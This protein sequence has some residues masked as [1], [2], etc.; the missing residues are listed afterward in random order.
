MSISMWQHV[1]LIYPQ[2]TLASCWDVKLPTNNNY[3]QSVEFPQGY[4]GNS[5]D[6]DLSVGCILS[7]FLYDALVCPWSESFS[8]LSTPLPCQSLWTAIFFMKQT[9]SM[10]VFPWKETAKEVRMTCHDLLWSAFLETPKH[11]FTLK[12][13][14]TQS[15][16]CL[17][18]HFD[19]VVLVNCCMSHLVDLTYHNLCHF[20][21]VCAFTCNT[22]STY[23]M[24]HVI[25]RATC[26]EGTAQACN[27]TRC[28]W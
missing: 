25:L 23:H 3:P 13:W 2:D 27:T 22:S 8:S 17:W 14:K 16:H 10:W 18:F 21:F 28:T 15:E 7:P 9:M 6:V 4:P 5:A 26:Y 1:W 11:F 12:K 24:Q 19:G 20:L